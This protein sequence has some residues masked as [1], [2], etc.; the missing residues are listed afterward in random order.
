MKTNEVECQQTQLKSYLNEKVQ[1]TILFRK[2]E[3]YTESSLQNAL[4]LMN[5]SAEKIILGTEGNGDL[6]LDKIFEHISLNH[7]VN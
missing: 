3:S 4:I 2:K 1:G 7:S 6:P 5:S